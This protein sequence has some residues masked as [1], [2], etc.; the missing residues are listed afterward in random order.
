[1]VTSG[2]RALADSP[3]KVTRPCSPKRNSTH[4]TLRP[5]DLQ[6]WI[7]LGVG[8]GRRGE[9]RITGG[10]DELKLSVLVAEGR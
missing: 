5:R 1:M 4:H 3:W 9:L 6:V 2:G 7:L 8:V 10:V